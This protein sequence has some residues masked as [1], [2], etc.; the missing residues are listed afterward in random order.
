MPMAK[1]FM[2]TCRSAAVPHTCG[3]GGQVG[4]G[5]LCLGRLLGGLFKAC[6]AGP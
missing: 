5:A 1:T 3:P 2:P 6:L 4:R